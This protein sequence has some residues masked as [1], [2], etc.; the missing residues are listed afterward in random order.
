[1]KLIDFFYLVI[2]FLHKK[3]MFFLE[4][5]IYKVIKVI[6]NLIFPLLTFKKIPRFGRVR[7]KNNEYIIISL[8]SYSKRIKHVWRTVFTLLSQSTK[9]NKVILWLSK[10]EFSSISDLPKNLTKLTKHGLEISFCN[11]LKSHKKYYYSMKYFPQAIVVTVDDDIYYPS[12]LLENLY[13]KHSQYP[14]AV[15]C[16]W[17]HEIM[18]DDNGNVDAYENWISAVDGHNNKPSKT[19]FPVGYGGILYPPR[20]LDEQVYNKNM[21]F[22]Y[23]L[24]TDDIWLKVN[25][26][27]R[28]T[29]AIKTDRIN[30]NFFEI[31]S[32]KK[33]SLYKENL[34]ENGANNQAIILLNKYFK[35]NYEKEDCNDFEKKSLHN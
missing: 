26:L 28:G 6:L 11:D 19:L 9:P 2:N 34:G 27:E 29:K 3:K 25:E 1:M 7:S 31:I 10:E 17:A 21:I 30:T 16:N 4:K 23:A 33:T 22:K 14:D 32:D 18:F 5:Y 8:T 24:S 35:K 20:S 13:K 15:C 12:Y